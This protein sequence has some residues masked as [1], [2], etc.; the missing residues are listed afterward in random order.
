M[1]AI[2]VYESFWGN[3]A[4]IAQAIADGIGSDTRAVNTAE[5]TQE[6]LAGVDLIVAGAPVLGF[7][8]PSET[9]L[10][11]LARESTPP[12]PGTLERPALRTWLGKLPQGSGHSAAFETRISWSP[13]GATGAITQALT[14]AGY[15][16]IVERERFI[17]TGRYGPLREGE[18]ERA[19]AWGASVKALIDSRPYSEEK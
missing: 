4:A 7:S 17:V 12:L 19:R 10:R 6:M 18:L 13:G 16:P 9:M 2:V 11:G 8:L 1:K 14:R 3:T 15:P 5:A